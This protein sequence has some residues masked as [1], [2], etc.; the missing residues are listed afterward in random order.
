MKHL[1]TSGG[2]R[3][4]LQLTDEEITQ[5]SHEG[6]CASDVL[7]L[8]GRSFIALQ[9]AA[10]DAEA[11]RNELRGIGAWNETQMEDH[12]ENLVRMVWLACVNLREKLA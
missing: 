4:E 2:G 9:V 5:G 10:W 7:A 6:D 3:L 8:L 11:L 12:H 1:W